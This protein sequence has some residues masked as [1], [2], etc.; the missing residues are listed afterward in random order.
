M[1]NAPSEKI[2]LCT[3]GDAFEKESAM[4]ET[5]SANLF[6][7]PV[8]SK[9]EFSESPI[10]AA[11]SFTATCAFW[12]AFAMPPATRGAFASSSVKRITNSSAL[13]FNFR[14]PSASAVPNA[15]TSALLTDGIFSLR[16]IKSSFRIL[17][18]DM[19]CEICRVTPSKFCAV[20][21]AAATPFANCAMVSR[22]CSADSP[23]DCRRRL[24]C[25]ACSKSMPGAL[26]TSRNFSSS[27][28]AC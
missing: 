27:S 17:P 8:I 13:I 1:A 15:V 2:S 3:S 14:R 12:I 18:L 11:A 25:T 24:P 7:A 28:L 26:A 10:L 20:P 6:S 22:A 5:K 23:T 4:P 16:T 19:I 21:P 9:A